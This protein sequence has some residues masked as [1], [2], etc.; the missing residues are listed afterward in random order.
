VRVSLWAQVTELRTA[1]DVAR[2]E[3]QREAAGLRH[4]LRSAA[5]A[6]AAA[7]DAAVAETAQPASGRASGAALAATAALVRAFEEDAARLH[8]EASP[9]MHADA[10]AD[11]RADPASGM[12]CASPASAGGPVPALAVGAS[13]LSASLALMHVRG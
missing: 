5:A 3:Q 7:E 12:T 1:L 8:D 10:A 11:R 2:A 9:R 13:T 4:A 6:A